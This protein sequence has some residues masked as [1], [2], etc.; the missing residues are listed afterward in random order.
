MQAM[1]TALKCHTSH[2][3]IIYEA[4]MFD[5]TGTGGLITTVYKNWACQMAEALAKQA[6]A[7]FIMRASSSESSKVVKIWKLR[8][9]GRRLACDFG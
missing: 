7:S 6:A 5:L 2:K 8:Y 9:Q 4:A 1:M 3:G